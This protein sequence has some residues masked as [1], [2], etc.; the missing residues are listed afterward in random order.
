MQPQLD[1]WFQ[2]CV[3][4][5]TKHQQDALEAEE[6]RTLRNFKVVGAESDQK[7]TSTDYE[8]GLC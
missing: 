7:Q 3:E 8:K 2:Q 4:A 6:Q 5:I 1:E